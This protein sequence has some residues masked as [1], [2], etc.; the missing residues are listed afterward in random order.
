MAERSSAFDWISRMSVKAPQVDQPELCIL[1][2]AAQVFG[3]ALVVNRELLAR[4][5]AVTWVASDVVPHFCRIDV[6]ALALGVLRRLPPGGGP[7]IRGQTRCDGFTA[8]RL[9]AIS[10]TRRC[11]KRESP[12]RS[13]GSISSRS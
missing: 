11:K 6:I 13:S 1:Q 12:K 7:D 9:R 10:L 2:G 3:M 8:G 5:H 4:M